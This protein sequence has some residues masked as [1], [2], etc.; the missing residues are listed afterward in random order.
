[1]PLRFRFTTA[2]DD[3]TGLRRSAT[4]A[5]LG[6]GSEHELEFALESEFEFAFEFEFEVE[7]EF[8]LAVGCWLL[9]MA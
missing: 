9:V 7:F 5:Q 1:M 3:A 4:E 8:A 6:L 2:T